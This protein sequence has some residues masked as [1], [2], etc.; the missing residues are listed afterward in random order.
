M[1][2]N[3]PGTPSAHYMDIILR[4]AVQLNLAPTYM[5]KLRKMPYTEATGRCSVY[6]K[7]I[8]LMPENEMNKYEIEG[9]QG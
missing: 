2:D 5:E 4:G 1:V 6:E 9:L 3:I 7:C 8:S